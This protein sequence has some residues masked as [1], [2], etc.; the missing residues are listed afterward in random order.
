MDQSKTG[1]VFLQVQFWNRTGTVPK[2]TE[3]VTDVY[4]EQLILEPV[5]IGFKRFQ[6]TEGHEEGGVPNPSSQTNFHLYPGLNASIV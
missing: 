3:E 2:T 1:P 5:R 6:Q 4:I